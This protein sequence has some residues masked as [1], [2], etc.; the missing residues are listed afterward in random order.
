MDHAGTDHDIV[1]FVRDCAITHNEKAQTRSIT[2][3]T[4]LSLAAKIMVFDV[5]RMNI[6]LSNLID[7]AINYSPV[8]TTVEVSLTAD[9]KS[10]TITVRDH[11]IGI[12]ET[13]NKGL[14]AK[15]YRGENAKRVRTSGTGL[16]LYL[17]KHIIEAHGGSISYQ[18]NQTDGTIFTI[19]LPDKGP[20]TPTALEGTFI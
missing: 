10:T 20:V 5:E 9:A 11:G 6:A 15:F 2:I 12:P 17:T 4:N 14:F 19:L 1:A 3:K 18:S 7:N 8:G 13:E 16:G